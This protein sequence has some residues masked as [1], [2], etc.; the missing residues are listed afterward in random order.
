[1]TKKRG[2][3]SAETIRRQRSTKAANLAERAAVRIALLAENEALKKRVAELEPLVFIGEHHFPDLTW[4]HRCEEQHRR[5]A[6]L[7]AALREITASLANEKMY[8]ADAARIASH[9]LE[10][11]ND[12]SR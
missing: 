4:K 2:P 7:E 8:H 6:V 3:R 12:P 9:A 10:A 11:A 5:I 1:M